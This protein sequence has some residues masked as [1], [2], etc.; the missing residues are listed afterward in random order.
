MK[1]FS[2]FFPT[3]LD[4]SIKWK[5][6]VRRRFGPRRS[7]FSQ[8]GHLYKKSSTFVYLSDRPFLAIWPSTF[9]KF[10]CDGPWD[11]TAKTRKVDGNNSST[12]SADHLSFLAVYFDVLSFLFKSFREEWCFKH[13]VPG[14]F[15]LTWVGPPTLTD[16]WS[17]H[18]WTRN[19]DNSSIITLE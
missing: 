1:R 5:W 10:W 19:C 4:Q 18:F 13:Q 9:E 3:A 15:N 8:Y 11:W 2:S 14:T 16:S 6:A 17:V 12:S 7:A